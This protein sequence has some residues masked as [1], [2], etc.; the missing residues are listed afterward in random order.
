[1]SLYL[2]QIFIFLLDHLHFILHFFFTFMENLFKKHPLPS[3]M[4]DQVIT[5]PVHHL[6]IALLMKSVV[7]ANTLFSFPMMDVAKDKDA[8][9]IP[10]QPNA[11][12]PIPRR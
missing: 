9:I 7:L 1:M 5:F 11:S 3:L 8:K 6:Q 12:S 10:N 2:C 4:H